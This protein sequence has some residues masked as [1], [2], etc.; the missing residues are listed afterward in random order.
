MDNHGK[1]A[2][3]NSQVACALIEMESMKAANEERASK[4]LAQAYDE[5]AFMALINRYGI[6]TNAVIGWLRE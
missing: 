5:G 4:G 6:H 2:H 3:I 1:A